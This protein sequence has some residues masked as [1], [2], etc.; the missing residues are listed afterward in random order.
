MPHLV[1]EVTVGAQPS[2]QAPPFLSPTATLPPLFYRVV[3]GGGGKIP[4]AWDFSF[5]A[6]RDLPHRPLDPEMICLQV[7]RNSGVNTQEFGAV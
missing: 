6:F 5:L 3:T 2:C 4:L 7:Q 1:G